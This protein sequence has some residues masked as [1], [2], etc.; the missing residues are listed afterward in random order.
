MA[1]HAMLLPEIEDPGE[2]I[3][4][5]GEEARHAARSKRLRAGE[6]VLVLNGRGLVIDT[7][8]MDVGREVVL[9][10]R[11]SR[12][13]GRVRPSVHVYAAAPKGPRLADLVDGLSQVGAASFTPLATAFAKRDPSE[14]RRGRLERVAAESAKQSRRAWTLEIR[15]GVDL[16][17]ALEGGEGERVVVADASGEAYRGRDGGAESVRLLI[18]PEGGW[19]GDELEM[20]RARGAVVAGFGPHVMRIEVAAAVATGVVLGREGWE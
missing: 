6:P 9:A 14:K 7:E 2:T 1:A 11:S 10:V 3:V 19:R 20:A 16:G 12:V 18:G 8:A 4:V 15:E 5:S 17:E 13:E